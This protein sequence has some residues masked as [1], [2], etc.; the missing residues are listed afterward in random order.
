MEKPKKNFLRNLRLRKSRVLPTILVSVL[1]PIIVCVSTPFEIYMN[2]SSEFVFGLAD[3]LPFCIMIMIGMISFFIVLLLLLPDNFY[4]V[5]LCLILGVATMLFVQGTYL[6]GNLSLSGDNLGSESTSFFKLIINLVIWVI[7]IDSIIITA[8]FKDKKGYVRIGTIVLSCI[9]IATQIMGIMV[10]VF[11]NRDTQQNEGGGLRASLTSKN[12]TSCAKERNIFYFVIDRFDEQYAESALEKYG[13]IY[14]ELEGFTW[15]QDNISIYGHT[16]PAACNMLTGADYDVNQA[17][18]TYLDNSITSYNYLTFLNEN[19]YTVNVYGDYYYIYTGNVMPD[20]IANFGEGMYAVEDKLG[21]SINMM[22]LSLYRCLP[23]A[24]KDALGT[25]NSNTCN[26]YATSMMQGGLE[27]FQSSNHDMQSFL[28]LNS[29]SRVAGKQFSYIHVSG[30]HGA[31]SDYSV[32]F[33]TDVS[34]E[35]ATKNSF[36]IINK[37]LQFLKSEGLYENATIIIT[38][39][40]GEP[41]N[42]YT[43]LYDVSQTALFVKPSGVGSGKLITSL[44]QTS[45]DDIW[46]TIFASEGLVN[47]QFDLGQ[48]IFD[49][50]VE[51]NRKR[52]YIWQSYHTE[53]CNEYIYEINGSGSDFNNWKMVKQNHYDIGLMA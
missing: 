44:A 10:N 17:R 1:I 43:E 52:R 37:Y 50:H 29:F 18:E 49:I 5:V 2:N 26:N 39:D 6:N 35:N 27:E 20:Y 21:L 30:C 38:G 16:F 25:I 7:L 53:M 19:G 13:N 22:K 45:H 34:L 41:K 4:K 11:T 36:L 9:V 23:F 33:E 24:L 51:D 40:H 46:A 47:S 32:D 31:E 48:N 8:T 42:D 28:R 12:L 3:F 15:F 14:S